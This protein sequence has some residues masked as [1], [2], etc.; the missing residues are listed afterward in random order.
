MSDQRVSIRQKSF[1]QGR[2][3]FNNGRSSVD[4]LIRDI[5]ES[6]ARLKFSDAITTPEAMELHIPNKQETHQVRVQWRREDEMGVAFIS[7]EPAS[8]VATGAGGAS[9]TDFAERLQKLE[10]EVGALRRIVNELRSEQRER[11]S[12]AI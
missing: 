3:Y 9:A 5:S 10:S 8:A 2:L 7:N 4:C 6:G 1:L 11:H 12:Q